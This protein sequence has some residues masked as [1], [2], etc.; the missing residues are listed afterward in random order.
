MSLDVPEV[1]LK[2]GDLAMLVDY[3]P[4]PHG[5]EEGAVLEIFNVLGESIRVATVP[6]SAIEALRPD[7]MPSVRPLE[8]QS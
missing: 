3:V 5:G 1:Q 2:R 7:Q 8:L 4:H 6:V